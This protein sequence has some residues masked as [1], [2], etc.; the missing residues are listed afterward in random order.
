[1]TFK[2]G[3]GLIYPMWWVF[4]K[5]EICRQE[6]K[7]KEDKCGKISLEEDRALGEA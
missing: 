7:E 1:V 5:R 6:C 3:W 2:I 4:K